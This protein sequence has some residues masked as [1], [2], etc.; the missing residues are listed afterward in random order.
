MIDDVD[1]LLALKGIA[2][3]VWLAL[4]F[5]LERWRPLAEPPTVAKGRPGLWRLARNAGL[6]LANTGLSP[7]VVIPVSVWAASLT[8]WRPAAWS[9]GWSILIDVIILDL[10]IYW[11]HRANHEIPVLWRFHEVH[12]L[13]RFLDT[14]TAV[15]F[16]FGEVLL[17]A[18]VRVPVIIAFDVS[19]TAILVFETLVLAS[20]L[21]H[22]SNLAIPPRVERALA[23][24][25]VTPSIHWIHHHRIRR[26]TD[27][28]YGAIF[29]FWDRMFGSRSATKRSPAMPIG[30]EGREE[31]GFVGLLAR[32]FKGE[33][34]TAAPAEHAQG[35]SKPL[36]RPD[37]SA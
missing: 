35:G 7:L 32:P 31:R 26:D 15:R 13:D 4:L 3:A 21:F 5:G 2:L 29:S 24:V 34:G 23:Q 33:P 12:H 17:S 20:A 37:G 36:R 8:D 25:V 16:H 9:G 30:V 27:S 10:W 6:W 22:H 11:W 28:N 18:L 1:S 19:W 14:T